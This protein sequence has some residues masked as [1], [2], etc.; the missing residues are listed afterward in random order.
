MIEI[1]GGILLALFLLSL[2]GTALTMPPIK[3]SEDE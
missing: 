3:E 1:A 2:L